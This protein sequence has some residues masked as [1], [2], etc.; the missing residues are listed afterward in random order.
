METRESHGKEK[1]P[2]NL[3][4]KKGLLPHHRLL[5]KPEP[6]ALGEQQMVAANSFDL[7]DKSTNLGILT[8]GQILTRIRLLFTKSLAP[9][10][11]LTF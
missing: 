10:Q 3:W 6:T 11:G 5:L 1:R 8:H 2:F 7:W 9:G 4:G